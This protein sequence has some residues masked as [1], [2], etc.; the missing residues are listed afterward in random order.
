MTR[1]L[2]LLLP[3][4]TVVGCEPQ[5]RGRPATEA[6][7]A[8]VKPVPPATRQTPA[9]P[10]PPK[11]EPVPPPTPAVQPAAP[12]F[13]DALAEARKRGAEIEKEFEAELPAKKKLLTEDELDYLDRRMWAA[14]RSD[15]AVPGPEAAAWMRRRKLDKWVTAVAVRG[16]CADES[17]VKCAR[18]VW[19]RAPSSRN[20]GAVMALAVKWGTADAKELVGLVASMDRVERKLPIGEDARD[21][22]LLFAGEEYL[23]NRP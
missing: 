8:A 2:L 6:A 7:K 17:F 16:A 1:L 4:L 12:T 18:W 11:S 22:M 15:R 19:D 14:S 21:A 9:A 5:D 10:V 20:T 13:A 3:T 23:A